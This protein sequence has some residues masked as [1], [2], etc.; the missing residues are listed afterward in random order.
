ML[1][2]HVAFGPLETIGDCKHGTK[3]L[4]GI[5][6]RLQEESLVMKLIPVKT[7]RGDELKIEKVME[8]G[9]F[10]AEAGDAAQIQGHIRDGLK[11]KPDSAVGP[12]PTCSSSPA[13]SE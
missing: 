2:W 1:Y 6:F 12:S 10:L 13:C 5:S 3:D 4:N 7:E 11:V 8:V 9:K